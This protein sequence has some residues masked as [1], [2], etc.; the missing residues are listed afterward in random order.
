MMS[1]HILIVD[2]D[3]DMC[4]MLHDDLTQRGHRVQ[5]HTSSERAFET[6]MRESFDTV[7]TDLKM[8]GL[9][10]IDFCNRLSKNRPDVP[11]IVITAF[12]TLN[13]AVEAIRAGAY[14]FVTK[15]IETDLLNIVI[16]RALKH[17]SLQE[18]VTFLKKQNRRNAEDF[19]EFIGRSPAM[20]RLFDQISRIADQQVP[21][22]IT[23]ES[24]TGKELVA[25]ALH[26]HSK[27]RKASFI[28]VNCA[29][30]P[31]MLLE[32]ELFGHA[33]GAFTDARS[34][35]RGLFTEANGG[36]LFLDEI[37]EIPLE[38]QPK[39]LRA[40]ETGSVRPIGENMELKS[41]V[42]IIAATN[43]DLEAAVEEGIFRED[44]FFR[45][46]VVRLIVPPL[47]AR[48]RDILLLAQ[49]FLQ[50]IAQRDEKSVK[51]L[52]PSTAEKLL[53]YS[54]PGNVRELR[55]AM[56]HALAL[57]RFEEV[58]VEDLPDKIRNYK[59]SQVVLG[60]S[61]PDELLTLEDVERQ[62]VDY[63]LKA[64]NGN[65]SVAARIL[66]LGRRT[67]YRKLENWGI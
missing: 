41:N 55:N 33:Q 2:D 4:E 31:G 12:G 61:N 63:V 34:D 13:T 6:F 48:G 40:V 66:G 22:L 46:N 30:L 18:Q 49:Y 35:R 20:E 47:R 3:Q 38:L 45:I 65:K 51:G 5:W 39:L 1:G 15:P 21:V 23:G 28:P 8:P 36:S 10:G 67:L 37:A 27:R 62:Y 43:R 25:R 58:V 53:A 24:G 9:N 64:A 14:D 29:A 50:T 52:S 57:T 56:E 32:S 19:G 7:I 54:W 59:S 60:G 44:L 26:R 17:R 42:R 16:N 11:V